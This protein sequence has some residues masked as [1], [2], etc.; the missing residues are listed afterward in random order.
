MRSQNAH[1]IGQRPFDFRK[2]RT[3]C[4]MSVRAPKTTCIDIRILRSGFK[5]QDKIPGT[6]V[7]R[8]LMFMWSSRRR[9]WQDLIVLVLT[10]LSYQGCDV[11]ISA[12]VSS[13]EAFKATINA[14]PR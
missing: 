11:R 3:V 6:V 5:A 14:V 12:K 10:A 13:S 8:I 7:C 9:V 4:R 2:D 1:P